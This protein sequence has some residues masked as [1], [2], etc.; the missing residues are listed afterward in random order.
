M[1]KEEMKKKNKKKKRENVR[2]RAR[3]GRCLFARWG[4]SRVG[5]TVALS[6]SRRY[7]RGIT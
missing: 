2:K 4:G 5:I 6:S 1:R 7:P 3:V